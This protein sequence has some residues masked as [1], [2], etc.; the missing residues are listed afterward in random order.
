MR[1]TN[2]L[3][4]AILRQLWVIIL[5]ALGLTVIAVGVAAFRRRCTR[6]R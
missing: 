2:A 5:V 1:W 3:G 6:P 4:S